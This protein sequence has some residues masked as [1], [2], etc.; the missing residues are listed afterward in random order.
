MDGHSITKNGRWI[1]DKIDY[2][3]IYN[4]MPKRIDRWKLIHM[5]KKRTQHTQKKKGKNICGKK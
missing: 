4:N 5:L 2:Q 3:E 1:P